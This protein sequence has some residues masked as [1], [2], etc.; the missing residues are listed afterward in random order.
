M[1]IAIELTAQVW[2]IIETYLKLNDE[3]DSERLS[4]IIKNHSIGYNSDDYSLEKQWTKDIG[5]IIHDNVIN[6]FTRSKVDR[7]S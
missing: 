2:E 5:N 3:S 1:T 6:G 4:K 7:H